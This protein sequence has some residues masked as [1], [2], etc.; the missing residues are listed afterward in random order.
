MDGLMGVMLSIVIGEIF[1]LK[2]FDYEWIK[3]TLVIMIM[4]G[5]W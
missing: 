5:F 4:D 3:N 2:S 1:F